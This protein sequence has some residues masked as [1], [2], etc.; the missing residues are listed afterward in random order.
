MKPGQGSNRSTRGW[1]TIVFLATA[2][3]ATGSGSLVLTSGNSSALVDADYGMGIYSWNV[4]GIE[5]LTQSWFWY[6][7]G[8]SGGQTSINM[9]SRQPITQP[10][11][12]TASVRYTAADIEVT[13]G[14]ELQGGPDGSNTSALAQAVTVRNPG[15]TSIDVHLFQY[16]DLDVDESY[17]ANAVTLTGTRAVQSGPQGTVIAT[18]F[19][20][21][22]SRWQVAAYPDVLDL[23]TGGEPVTLN[24]CGGPV[25]GDLAFALQWDLQLAPGAAARIDAT[26]IIPDPATHVLLA[27]LVMHLA[28]TRRRTRFA[29][30]DSRCI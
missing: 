3:T 24:N 21:A 18:Q 15:Q 22:A 14:L 25:T 29:R 27:C 9:L 16:I 11:A 26:S 4:E 1:V 30:G 28:L 7:L 8:P 20:P 10:D 2:T 17:S 23:L 13:L 6:R 5:H 12:N 19:V